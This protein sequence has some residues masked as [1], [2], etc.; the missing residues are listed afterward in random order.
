MVASV[1]V[2]PKPLR[3]YVEGGGGSQNKALTAEAQRAFNELIRRA[4][5]K[6]VGVVACGSRNEAFGD[7]VR[8]S[9]LA[10]HRPML[11]V[12]AEAPVRDV[13]APWAHLNERDGWDRPVAAADDDAHL[14]VQLMETWLLASPA[15]LNAR[16]SLPKWPV[17]EDVP[18][19]TILDVIA[20]VTNGQYEKGTRSF[21]AL[22]KVD[23]AVLR[24]LCP[25][26]ERFFAKVAEKACT[27]GD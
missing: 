22:A 2:R 12:D 15:A 18:K 13:H 11:L 5:G 26:A 19:K 7:F 10:R 6:A 3:L 8:A 16:R 1:P 17:L 14:M 4:T 21:K 23:P 9:R 20:K 27:S 24:R 25:A